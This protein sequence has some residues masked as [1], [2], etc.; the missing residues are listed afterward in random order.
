MENERGLQIEVPVLRE[1]VE[2]QPSIRP[3]FI[4]YSLLDTKGS[5]E[6]K[7]YGKDISMT[8]LFNA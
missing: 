3:F 5:K 7:S 8:D 1:M 4:S 6:K 2:K